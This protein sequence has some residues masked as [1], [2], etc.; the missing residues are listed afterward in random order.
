MRLKKLG[1]GGYLTKFI[2]GGSAPRSN[3][4]PFSIACHFGRKG[5]P[6]MYLLL[7]RYPFHTPTL[8]SLVLVFMKCL[9]KVLNKSDTAIR[10]IY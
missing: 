9:I 4:S 7:K 5:T 3:P 8:G 2:R 1:G 6:F 10:G